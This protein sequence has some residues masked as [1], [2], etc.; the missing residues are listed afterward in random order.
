MD[1]IQKE[2]KSPKQVFQQPSASA[3]GF[4]IPVKVARQIDKLVEEH[5][6]S[7]KRPGK[8]E[9]LFRALARKAPLTVTL[10]ARTVEAFKKTSRWFVDRAHFPR[11]P[12]PPED[13]QTFVGRFQE[14]ERA[15]YVLV[16]RLS[17]GGFFVGIGELDDILQQ[18]NR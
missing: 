11:Q 1:K 15:I 16:E 9:L 5:R 12:L 3:D 14:F 6:N 10:D 2:W 8:Y 13:E 18:A 4:T 17:E 7:R